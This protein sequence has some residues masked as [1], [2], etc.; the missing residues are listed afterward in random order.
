M[1]INIL[2]NIN[3]ANENDEIHYQ[4]HDKKNLIMITNLERLKIV[5]NYKIIDANKYIYFITLL[6]LKSFNQIS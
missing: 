6:M 2:N 3:F 5:C 1:L 4:Y